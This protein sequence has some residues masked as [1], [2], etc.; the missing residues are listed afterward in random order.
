MGDAAAMPRRYGDGMVSERDAVFGWVVPPLASGSGAA[1]LAPAPAG[2]HEDD[3]Q[4]DEGVQEL[5]GGLTSAA[6]VARKPRAIAATY[7]LQETI[8]RQVADTLEGKELSQ[9]SW[10][11]R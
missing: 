1:A 11:E 9:A 10:Q 4:D 6:D 2:D 3:E 7:P 8:N 5:H